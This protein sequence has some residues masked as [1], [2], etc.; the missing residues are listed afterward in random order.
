VPKGTGR[1]MTPTGLILF[2]P[3]PYRGFVDSLSHFVEGCEEE[4]FGLATI[5]DKDFGDVS[6]VDVDSDDHG[7]GIGKQG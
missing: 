2:L 1:V 5:V 6:S 4:D 3:K 7:I